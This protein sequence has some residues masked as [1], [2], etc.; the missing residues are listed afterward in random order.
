MG[1]KGLGMEVPQQVPGAEPDEGSEA[2]STETRYTY[3]ICS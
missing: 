2:K 1:I 3:T